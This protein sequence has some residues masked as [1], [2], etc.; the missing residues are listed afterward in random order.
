MSTTTNKERKLIVEYWYRILVSVSL[1]FNDIARIIVEF[2]KLCDQFDKLLVDKEIILNNDGLML[3]KFGCHSV[4]KDAFGTFIAKPG[5]RYLWKI[6]IM[7]G[8]EDEIIVNIG[9]AAVGFCSFDEWDMWCCAGHGYAYFS[10]G[11]KYHDTYAGRIY[12]ESF[13]VDDVIHICLDLKDNYDIS[14]CKNGKHFGK[15]FDV[16]KEEEYKL[17]IGIYYGQIQLIDFQIH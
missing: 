13:G 12:G 6:K 2:G 7:R 10:G 1:A 9:V 15:G 5:N 17:A 4:C 11:I 14:W 3:S 16:E 8:D